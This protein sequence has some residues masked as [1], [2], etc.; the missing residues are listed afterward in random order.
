MTTQVDLPTNLALL[1]QLML[2]SGVV[3][4]RSKARFGRLS[5]SYT[6]REH[7]GLAILV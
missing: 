1:V 6:C 2:P 3:L 4:S 5:R 7:H